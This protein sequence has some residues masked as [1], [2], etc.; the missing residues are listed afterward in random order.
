MVDY[1]PIDPGPGC[2]LTAVRSSGGTG[3]CWGAAGAT[4]V[5]L[6]LWGAATG[7]GSLAFAIGLSLVVAVWLA[8]DTTV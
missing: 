4:G 3:A 5:L 8:D 2:V 7:R 6:M 1:Y